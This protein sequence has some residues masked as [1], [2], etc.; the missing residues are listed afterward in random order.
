MQKLEITVKH[1]RQSAAKKKKFPLVDPK[2][3]AVDQKQQPITGI[4]GLNNNCSNKPQKPGPTFSDFNDLSR[5]GIRGRLSD[6]KYEW[7]TTRKNHRN[8]ATGLCQSKY[9]NSRGNWSAFT[10]YNTLSH[11]FL[12]CGNPAYATTLFIK[13]SL[14]VVMSL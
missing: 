10:L 5:D 4:T 12:D 1:A 6:D 2:A 8:N 3:H 7:L 14:C 9:R 13:P 11:T